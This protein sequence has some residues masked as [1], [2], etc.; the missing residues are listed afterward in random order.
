MH[1]RCRASNYLYIVALNL[2]ASSGESFIDDEKMRLT[3]M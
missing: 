1:R 2:I 3:R